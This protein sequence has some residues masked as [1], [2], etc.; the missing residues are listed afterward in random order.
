MRLHVRMVS[1]T[2]LIAA[3][4]PLVARA[5]D[6]S[7][8]Q[9]AQLS[10]QPAPLAASS[11]GSQ[12]VSPSQ[13][14]AATGPEGVSPH[15]SQNTSGDQTT[16]FTP[17]PTSAPPH[18]GLFP[19]FGATLLNDGIDIHGIVFDHFLANPTA[20]VQPGQTSNLAAFRPAVDLDL[21]RL[22][23]L[24][25]GYVHFGMTFFGLRSDLPQVITQTGGVIDG[26]QTTPA[27][28]TAIVSIL[29]YEQRLLNNKLSIEFGRT[30][31]YNYF[32]LPNSLDPFSYYST[33]FQV[34]GDF[35]STPY[36][37]WGARTTYKLGSSWYLQG[38]AFEDD[39]VDSTSYGDRLGDNHASGAQILAEIG[40]RSEFT[41][42]AYPSNFEAGFE[43]NTRTGRNNLKGTGAPAIFPLQIPDY[44]GGGVIFLQGEKVIWRG[45]RRLVGPPQNIAIYG[46]LDPSVDKPQ[47]IDLDAMIGV[48]FTGFI[49]GRPFDVLEFQTRYQRLSQIEANAES[50]RED[51]VTGDIRDYITGGGPTQPRD[52]YSFEAVA[53]IQV[54]PAVAFRPILEY[55]INPDNYYPPNTPYA[56]PSSG[57]EAGF[58]AV[59]SLG[60]LLGT[61]LKPF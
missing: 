34:T 33:S 42:S 54:T 20:G 18:I 12:S 27:T 23:G 48:N 26:F 2:V 50:S 41:N 47:P 10:S 8:V 11:A 59:I 31:A 51:L 3:A 58:F 14:P 5:A 61:S 52:A 9:L 32:L 1:A 29:T 17:L 38:G 28:Q 60:R 36:P 22:L 53:N 56:R 40:Q 55:F 16:R 7:S 46:S 25:G 45:P 57:V 13:N 6:P 24:T 21:G 37:V 43:W 15:P 19:E 39:Y 4:V 30:N 35:A 44:Q 49:P